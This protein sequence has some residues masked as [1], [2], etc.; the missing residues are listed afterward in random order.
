MNPAVPAGLD[1]VEGLGARQMREHRGG[2]GTDDGFAGVAIVRSRDGNVMD[3]GV[4]KFR[5]AVQ[6]MPVGVPR[7]HPACCRRCDDILVTVA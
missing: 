4:E 2:H 5:P 7:V 3:A 1:H 6:L